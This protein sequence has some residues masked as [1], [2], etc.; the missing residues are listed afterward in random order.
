MNRIKQTVFRNI[1]DVDTNN[2]LALT[3]KKVQCKHKSLHDGLCTRHTNQI[4]IIKIVIQNNNI[5]IPLVLPVEE[6][7]EVVIEEVQQNILNLDLNDRKEGQRNEI[8]V[9][10]EE[11]NVNNVNHENFYRLQIEKSRLLFEYNM[12]HTTILQLLIK[13]RNIPRNNPSYDRKINKIIAITNLCNGHL[14]RIDQIKIEEERI[15]TEMTRRLLLLNPFEQMGRLNYSS[16]VDSGKK[17]GLSNV[18]P[19]NIYTE[20]N[21]PV[22]MES[23]DN[24]IVL[25]CGH[26]AH[27]KCILTWKPETPTCPSCLKYVGE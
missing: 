15:N 4:G 3:T 12:Y 19:N 20:E 8:I 27:E 9:H 24:G 26:V 7:Q 6:K 23:N 21:C 16:V 11:K 18:I 13:V 2:C 10:E 22:C 5:P 17:K 25:C 1:N 14:T